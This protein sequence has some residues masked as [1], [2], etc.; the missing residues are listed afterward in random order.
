MWKRLQA[1]WRAEGDL[2]QLQGLGDRL[3]TDM[4][5]DRDDLRARVHGRTDPAPAPRPERHGCR[6]TP[7][8][9]R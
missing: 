9:V 6:P 7:S 5:L 2:A 1:W 3:L 4:G 8:V